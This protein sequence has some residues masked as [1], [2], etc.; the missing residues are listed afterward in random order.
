MLDRS[1]SDIRKDYT[2]HEL[3][4]SSVKPNPIN[5]F[6]VWWEEAKQSDIL[7]VNAMTLSTTGEEGMPESRIV[8]L[9]GFD[10]AGFVFFTNYNSA[11]SQQLE[12]DP[13]CSVLFFWKELE[14]QV[15][16]TG[17]AEKI[18]TEESIQYFNSRPDGSK[19]GAWASPQSAVVAGAAWL[20][21]TYQYYAER[22]KHGEIPKPPHWGGFRVKPITV[23]FWQGRPS[24]MHDRIKYSPHSDQ[25]GSYR[26]ERLA[27]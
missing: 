5:Q 12:R 21:E 14:R 11:K 6:S 3:H 9:K 23:E 16:I 24:R 1:I 20:K 22:F 2:M 7:E 26:I 18:S 19:I 10:Q 13:R 8:L 4:E 25:P 15:R 17:L 27:P